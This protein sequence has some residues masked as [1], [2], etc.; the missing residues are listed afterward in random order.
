MLHG[1]THRLSSP[2]GALLTNLSMLRDDLG[3][4]LS[5]TRDPGSS[6]AS[7]N[8]S[9]SRSVEDVAGAIE[10]VESLRETLIV[11][12]R[13]GCAPPTDTRTDLLEVFQFWLKTS[14]RAAL[15]TSVIRHKE[16]AYTNQ[17]SLVLVQAS[18]PAICYALT[19]AVLMLADAGLSKLDGGQVVITQ[20][21]SE[22]QV[23]IEM[24]CSDVTFSPAALRAA[25]ELGASTEVI[26]GAQGPRIDVAQS[27]RGAVVGLSLR[28]ALQSSTS[29]A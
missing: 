22:G 14:A 9:L 29:Y 7:I 18:A 21:A 28:S 1:L 10:I 27:E 20:C 5:I 4:L 16:P 13:V 23:R 24:T 25:A 3:T 19:T 6:Q 26:F 11:T 15:G 17:G 12:K 2:V 8:E